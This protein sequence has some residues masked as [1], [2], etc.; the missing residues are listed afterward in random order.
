MSTEVFRFV[1]VHPPQ[2][3]ASLTAAAATT[4]DLGIH[5]TPF[6][7]SLR[8]M[9]LSG[10]RTAM[11]E[12][13]T[14]FVTSASFIDSSGKLEEPYLEFM[15]ALRL[16]AE[17][18]FKNAAG[19]AFTQAFH[20]TPAAFVQT[21]AFVTSYTRVS[22]GIVA[23][24]I[25]T[26]V[27]AKVR[28]LLVEVA[29]ALGLVLQLAGDVNVTRSGYAS[30]PLVLPSGIFP[31]PG[32]AAD[33]KQQRT[34]A[35]AAQ[36]ARAGVRSQQVTRLTAEL[37]A[38]SQAVDELL[39]ALTRSE[40]QPAT[41]TRGPTGFAL[42]D[43][44]AE[45][46]TDAT[47]EVLRSAGLAGGRI[48]VA[49][50]VGLLE[51]RSAGIARRLYADTG[52]VTEMV[53][54]GNMIIPRP[55]LAGELVP[56]SSADLTDSRTPGPCPPAPAT[57][58]PVDAVTVP[59]G[60][61]DAK[62]LGIAD[63]M[64]VEQDLLRYQLGE[65]GHI[66]NV[67][68]SE[69]RNRTFKTSSTTEQTVTTETETSEEKS[70][71]LSS[72]ERFELQTE[73]QAV[74]NDTASKSGGLTIHASYGP[75]VD[76][77][78]NFNFASSSSRQ[79]STSASASYAREVTTKAASRVETRTLTRRTVRTL[80]V[81][82]ETSE[83]GFDNKSG[84][85]D[86]VGVYRYVDKVYLAQVVNYG[87]RLMLEFVVPEPA[88]FLRH[89][90][91]HRPLGG[92]TA[93]EPQPPGYCLAD[94]ASFV[95][96]QAED[97]TRENYLFWAS[98][99]GARDVSPPP[100]SV[101]LAS[102]A[103]KSA[104]SLPLVGDRK[105]SSDLMDVAIADGYLCQSAF[106]NIY[107][108][109]QAGAHKIV[110]QLQDQQ[111]EYVEPVDDAN[112]FLLHLQ[113]TPTLGVT[114]NSLGFHNY[115]VL[116]T[117]FCR[118][119]P[120][121]FQAWQLA[122]FHSIMNAYLDEK[123]RFDQQVAEAQLQARDTTLGGT[124]P[125]RN[126][127]VEQI[128]LRKACVSLLTGQRF[129]LFDAVSRNVAPYGYPEIDFAEAQ[130]E[131]PYIQVFEQSFEWNNMT[132]VFYPYF[133]GSKQEWPIL[134]QLSDE[135][136][137]F[138]RFLTAG[139]ARVQV[140]VRRGF[141]ARVLTYLATGELWTGDG[142][143]VN[144]DDGAPDQL[145]LSILDEL[146]SQLGDNTVRGPG[147]ITVSKSSANVTGNGTAFTADD[148]DRRIR[149]GGRT[150]VIK[151]V[152]DEQTITLATPYPGES[153]AGISYSLGGKL[154]GEPWEVKLP[155][156]LVKLDNMLVIS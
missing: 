98:T 62:V 23:A 10:S 103:K 109:T 111:R 83:H 11:I 70:Q 48:D 42:A 86:I 76:A 74:I 28:A 9:R 69:T 114:I 130:A 2:E 50:A 144:S 113:P 58:I 31:L 35:A 120:E 67:L 105:I 93:A 63:L 25:V 7:D 134:A 99:Y 81:V 17:H 45:R 12:A 52:T 80:H 19:Q 8:A 156:N 124:N 116:V 115:E 127:E 112:P 3:V 92:V 66:E 41:A 51:R 47:K 78:S 136:P 38:H 138:A 89:A 14:A 79:Q 18:S 141:E 1:T 72:A 122:T 27:P 59:T 110:Y 15:A 84:S 82:E 32:V 40:A 94:G 131:G 55:G 129:D 60:H 118:L 85:N 57:G 88:A 91:T 4:T 107:G 44:V 46:L 64:V 150:Y 97:I 6:A 75:S 101:I 102:G 16:L 125:L 139:A 65:V 68:K 54:I 104:D 145:H 128:E 149:F 108:E 13:A 33:L 148:V 133:W 143:L 30:A 37:T 117:V 137:L 71:D 77:T 126:R 142:T 87:K 24:T 119:A 21:E 90:M 132:Y 140:P 151:T 154:V 56:G 100:P 135:D 53:R 123:S 96:L 147:T 22:D 106:V 95:P 49:K 39:D 153:A 5:A 155:T 61:G 20:T 43:A 73:S 121:K 29:R 152:V 26:S 34:A 36:R 146:R